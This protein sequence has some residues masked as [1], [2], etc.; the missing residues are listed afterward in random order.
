MIYLFMSITILQALLSLPLLVLLLLLE[1]EGNED[2]EP[3]T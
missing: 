2:I 1:D 3:G